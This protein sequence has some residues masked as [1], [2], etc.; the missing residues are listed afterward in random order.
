V[1]ALKK[2]EDLKAGDIVWFACRR[3]G[4]EGK[5]AKVLYRRKQKAAP[6]APAVTVTCYICQTCTH[7]Y[8]LTTG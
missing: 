1:G 2:K 8:V 4:C 7:P 3:D 5:Q 6:G